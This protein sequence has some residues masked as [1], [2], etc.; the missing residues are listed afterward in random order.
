MSRSD[1]SVERHSGRT[2]LGGGWQ[3]RQGE[4]EAEVDIRLIIIGD[5]LSVEEWVDS[6]QG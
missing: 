2:P 5:V 1:S 4:A 6:E 3:G